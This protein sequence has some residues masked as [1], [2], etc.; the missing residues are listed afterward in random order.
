MSVYQS[1][2][3]LRCSPNFRD[4]AE[5]VPA[6]KPGVLY[7]SDAIIDPDGADGDLLAQCGI[8]LVIDLRSRSERS[9]QPNHWWTAAGVEIAEFEVAIAGDPAVVM[10]PLLADQGAEGA[11]GM[12]VAAYATFPEGA[13]PM[14]RQV[15]ARMERDGLPVM[16]YCTAGKD[17][18]GVS[19]AFLLLALGIDPERVR[20]DYLASNGRQS[21]TAIDATRDMIEAVLSRPLTDA[22]L[23]RMCGVHADFLESAFAAVEATHGSIDAYLQAAGF[24]TARRDRLAALMLRD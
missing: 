17:R 7:R 2:A 1:A 18:T 11:H 23:A 22:G 20:A 5:T 15:G 14:L 19:I 13:L 8:R 24:D 4:V 16:I 21:Q 12:M 10:Q 9:A 3:T 6:L